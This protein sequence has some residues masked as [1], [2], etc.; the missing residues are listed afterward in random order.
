VHE[1]PRAGDA[2][3]GL[4]V[5]PGIE[6]VDASRVDTSLLGHS[7]YGDNK[8]VLADLFQVITYGL[9]AKRRTFLQPA[10]RGALQYF[11]FKTP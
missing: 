6:T 1:H 11:E 8:T 4:V 5:H 2:G 7:Y 9:P 10:T 3:E